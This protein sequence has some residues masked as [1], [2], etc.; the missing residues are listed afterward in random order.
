MSVPLIQQGV[1]RAGDAILGSTKGVPKAESVCLPVSNE[2]LVH[3]KTMQVVALL[4]L[5]SLATWA[6]AAPTPNGCSADGHQI[7]VSR[8]TNDCAQGMTCVLVAEQ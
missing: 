1:G 8:Q 5:L 4:T 6:Q 2:R 3:Q 7:T